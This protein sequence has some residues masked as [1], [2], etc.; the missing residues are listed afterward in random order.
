MSVG[1]ALAIYGEE[2]GPQTADPARIGYAIDALLPFWGAL[3]VEAVK[4]ATCRRYAK[5]RKAAPGTIRRSSARCAPRCA[6]APPRDT[7]WRP[8]PSRCRRRPRPRNAPS[9]ATR[10][11]ACCVPPAPPGSATSPASS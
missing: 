7:C 9:A 3:R 8:R 6:T 2:R 5:T 4:G 10:S 11:R 1:D